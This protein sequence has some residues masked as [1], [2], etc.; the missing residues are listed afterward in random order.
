VLDSIIPS[1]SNFRFKLDTDSGLSTRRRSTAIELKD[2]PEEFC[3]K[4]IDFIPYLGNTFFGSVS[5]KPEG[6]EERKQQ[7]AETGWF[8]NFLSK[9]RLNCVHPGPRLYQTGGMIELKKLVQREGY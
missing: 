6:S 5:P 4:E 1:E 3:G 8:C 2:R 7:T 9:I